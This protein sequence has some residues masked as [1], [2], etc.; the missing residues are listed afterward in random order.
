M[1]EL[2]SLIKMIHALHTADQEVLTTG[3]GIMKLTLDPGVRV[4]MLHGSYAKKHPSLPDIHK[5]MQKNPQNLNIK[6]EREGSS[7]SGCLLH[8]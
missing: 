6:I 8:V 1:F 5:N 3:L 7:G 2:L 4:H